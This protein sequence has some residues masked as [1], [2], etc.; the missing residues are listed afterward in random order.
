MPRGKS[1]K[2]V[3]LLLG[4]TRLP[5]TWVAPAAASTTT[6]GICSTSSGPGSY[7]YRA[8]EVCWQCSVEARDGCCSLHRVAPCASQHPRGL[9]W[10]TL[11]MAQ[12]ESRVSTQLHTRTT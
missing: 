5:L 1:K 6:L 12:Q 3:V 11:G 10:H 7:P 9:P 8:L 2:S 4:S